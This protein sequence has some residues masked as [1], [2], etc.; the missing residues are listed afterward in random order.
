MTK[1]EAVA[2]FKNA[3]ELAEELGITRSAVSQWAD[4]E[5]IP[6]VHE[7][8][9]RYEILPKRFLEQKDAA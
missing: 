1:R 9:I 6:E 3:A 4:D 8:R 2:L 7:L 5:S